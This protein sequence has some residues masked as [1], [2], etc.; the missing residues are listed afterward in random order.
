[1]SGVI[2][3]KSGREVKNCGAGNDVWGLSADLNVYE[4]YDSSS[5][6][7]DDLTASE[8]VEVCEAMIARWNALRRKLAE[9]L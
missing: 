6:D 3:L 1:M 8:K 5:S 2:K 7:W 9:D 4:G